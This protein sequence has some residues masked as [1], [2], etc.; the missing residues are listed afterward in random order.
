MNDYLSIE[1]EET[2]ELTAHHKNHYFRVPYEVSMSTVLTPVDKLLFSNMMSKFKYFTTKADH[3]TP[4]TPFNSTLSR[5]CGI[6]N[7]EVNTSLSHLVDLNLISVSIT[8]TGHRI[9]DVNYI[10]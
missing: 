8:P 7:D 2:Y 10:L 5:E 9:I 4:Y 6:S 3:P 1:E